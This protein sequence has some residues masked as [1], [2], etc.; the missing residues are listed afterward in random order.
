[1]SEGT[2]LPFFIGGSG[3][4]QCPQIATLLFS[5]FFQKIIR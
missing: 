2:L 4:L 1:L 3:G 5:R